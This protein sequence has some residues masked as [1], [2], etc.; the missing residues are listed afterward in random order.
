MAGPRIAILAVMAI[1]AASAIGFAVDAAT[2]ARAIEILQKR[3]SFGKSAI[4]ISAGDTLI[5]VN[6]DP[7]AHNV[8]ARQPK[9]WLDLGI[10]EEGDRRDALFDV[11]GVYDI[12]CRIHPKMRLT[13]TVGTR[14]LSS[15]I[16]AP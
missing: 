12:R 11:P 3:R 15:A 7:Y 1:A 10:L 14:S 2:G 9:D 4:A 16:P 8:Y 5:F 13:V 6:N